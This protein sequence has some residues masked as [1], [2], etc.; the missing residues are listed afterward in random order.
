VV[1][2]PARV[3]DMA[4]YD[5][6]HQYAEGFA[7]VIVNGQIVY[8][9]GVMT[10]ARPGKVLYS[11]GKNAASNSVAGHFQSIPR[12]AAPCISAGDCLLEEAQV[13]RSASIVIGWVI[14][15]WVTMRKAQ[16]EHNQSGF[17][18]ESGHYAGHAWPV[19]VVP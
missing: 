6:P 1:F 19:G 13:L 5:K 14:P 15:L 10:T 17:I 8:E 12:F 9:N 16:I 2:D 11:A 4:T 3:R 18:G 7:Y